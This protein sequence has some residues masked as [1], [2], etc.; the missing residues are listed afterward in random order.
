MHIDSSLFL[1]INIAVILIF[2]ITI[3]VGYKNGFL[4]GVLNIVA[5]FA[6][7]FIAW[8]VGPVL[9]ERIP[10]YNN[11][12]SL[13]EV[14]IYTLAN[15]VLW[16]LIVF[17]IVRI[18]LYVIMKAT[19][20]V[21]KL[22]LIGSFNKILGALLGVVVGF[23]YTILLA[24]L[25]ASPLFDNG[26]EV[27]DN[28][29]LKPLSDISDKLI[30]KL[31]DMIDPEALDT[32]KKEVSSSDSLDEL[33]LKIDAQ[34]LDIDKLRSIVEDYIPEDLDKETIINSNEVQGAIESVDVTSLLSALSQYIDVD[35]LRDMAMEWVDNVN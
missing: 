20:L 19:K 7:A 33:A 11:F 32:E 14:V 23:F 10:L 26:Q 12:N 17:I 16:I 5:F 27:I 31:G 4:Y 30:V 13:S 9:A 18:V 28:T 8:V 24:T 22:P 3:L 21:S 6:S 15:F 1:I 35:E 2:L 34:D 29:L 25:I